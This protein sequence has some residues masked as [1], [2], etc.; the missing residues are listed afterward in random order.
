MNFK[1]GIIVLFMSVLHLNAQE[2]QDLSTTYRGEREKEN[3][4]V[5]TKLSVAFNFEK[6]QLSGEAWLTLAPHFYPT[7]SLT[8]DAKG[9]LIH[10]VTQNGRAL[11]YDYKDDVLKVNLGKTY[12]K[13]DQYT[14]YIKYT[15]RPDEVKQEGSAAINDAKGLYFIDPDQKD[16]E[17]PTQIWTQGETESSSCWFPTIDSPNQKTSQEIYIKVPEKYVTLSNGILVEQKNNNDGTRTDYWKLDQKHAPYLFFMGI[18]EYSIVKDKWKN[19][20]VD[21]YVEPAFEPYAKDIFGL[22]PEMMDFYS[23]YTGVDYMWPKYAQMVARDYVS[24][25]MENTTAVLHAE[26]AQQVPGQLIDENSWEYVIAHELF[27]HWFGDYVTAESWSNLTVNESFANY[28]EYLW[29]EHKYGKDAAD[30]H[31]HEEIQGYLAG[32]NELKDLVRFYYESREDMFDAVSYN[33]GGTILHML[34]SY[35]GDQAFRTGIKQYLTDNAYGTGE[36]HQ[37]RLAMEKVTGKDLNWFFNQWYFNNGHPKLEVKYDY[38]DSSKLVAVSISQNQEEVFQFPLTIQ[39]Y[40][41]GKPK[42]YPVWID[43]K[44]ESFSFKYTKRPEL[45]NVDSDRVLLVEINDSK[46]TENYVH[47]YLYGTTYEDRREAIENLGD[48]QSEKIAVTTLSKALND[49]YYGLR[50]LAIDKVDISRS[51][52]AEAIKHMEKLAKEDPKTLV[53]AAAIEKLAITKNEKYIPLY[54]EA[55]KSKSYAVQNAALSALFALDPQLG[56]TNLESVVNEKN[57]KYLKDALIPIYIQIKNEDQMPF[58]ADNLIAGMFFTDDKQTQNIYKE[59]FQWVVNSS[60]IEA[61]QNLVDS[62]VDMGIKYKDYGADQMARQVLNQVLGVKQ[63]SQY[64]NKAEMIKIV[65]DGLAKL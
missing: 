39:V 59:G 50:I 43:E 26:N 9:M 30:A 34:R 44:S 2:L 14:I 64:S 46:T 42:T 57:R 62:F 5:H 38:N 12:L 10:E 56:L 48:H 19:I 49:P 52:A 13:D 16:A 51:D 58:V 55:L 47:Q 20:D 35:L 22:T 54:N 7:S 32:G 27:H 17:K 28:G 21:Y 41:G 65:E 1:I 6:R 25:A 23:S 3:N 63:A 36:A 29:I 11:K 15:A 61:T 60:N 18:G 8:L 53:Q 4:L 31:R 40:E 37:L 24:G 33:K 45:V